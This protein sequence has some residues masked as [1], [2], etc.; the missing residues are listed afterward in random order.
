MACVLYSHRFCLDSLTCILTPVSEKLSICFTF[1]S[2][3]KTREYWQPLEN[4]AGLWG[5]RWLLDPAKL[6]SWPKAWIFSVNWEGVS[7]C[8][9]SCILLTVTSLC[10]INSGLKGKCS[11]HK[12]DSCYPASERRIL[13]WKSALR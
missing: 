4:R 1:M 11:F 7:I 6:S 9:Y 3:H 5:E 8:I 10:F 2:G 13:L 12:E